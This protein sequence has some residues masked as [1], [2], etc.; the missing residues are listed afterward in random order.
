MVA[1]EVRNLA[2]RSAKAAQ[3]TSELIAGSVEN[4]EKGTS[5]V[6][7][8]AH[9]FEEIVSGVAKV[10]DLV[11]EIASA[12]NEQTQGLSYV[13]NG[14]TQIENVTQQ[15]TASA[16]ETASA[17]ETLASQATQLRE[18]L[19]RF[20]LKDQTDQQMIEPEEA[21]ALLLGLDDR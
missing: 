11:G 20:I 6:D 16:E 15:N 14:L 10:T 17:A 2:S 5:I 4:V 21:P 19:T 3:E 18:L 12:S 9:A 7:Q 8:T 1:Q 13:S